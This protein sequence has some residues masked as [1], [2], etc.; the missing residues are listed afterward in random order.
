MPK[1][2]HSNAKIKQGQPENYVVDDSTTIDDLDSHLAQFEGR[3]P[4]NVVD[5]SKKPVINK[6]LENLVFMGK[7]S[8]TLEFAGHKFEISTLT[9][10]EHK[11]VMKNII[12][13]GDVSDILAIRVSALANALKSINGTALSEMEIDGVFED[14]FQKRLAIIDNIQVGLVD[15]LFNAYES[16]VKESDQVV[17][18][19]EVKK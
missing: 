2:E 1:I 3:S 10:K 17:Y 19:E 13:I 6:T 18:G 15:R 12:K 9:H 7:H 4:Q 8:K 11:Q 5:E 14:D 16:L